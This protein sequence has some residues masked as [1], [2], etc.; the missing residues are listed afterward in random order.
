M[1]RRLE[2]PA[3]LWSE[4]LGLPE[5]TLEDLKAIRYVCRTWNNIISCILFNTLYLP[6]KQR[7]RP[8]DQER[9]KRSIDLLRHIASSPNF[10]RHFEVISIDTDL[11]FQVSCGQM[12][13]ESTSSWKSRVTAII[14]RKRRLD[15]WACIQD[16]IPHL[17]ALRRMDIPWSHGLCPQMEPII[18]SLPPLATLAVNSERQ[19]FP[20][21][22]LSQLRGLTTLQAGSLTKTTNYITPIITNNPQLKKID[23]KWWE[24][25]VDLRALFAGCPLG[26][27]AC[28][29]SF[30]GHTLTVPHFRH[31]TSLQVDAE[32]PEALWDI[33]RR[34]T[35]HLVRVHICSVSIAFVRYVASYRGIERLELKLWAV[36]CPANV[37]SLWEVISLHKTT[38]CLL[39]LGSRIC[40]LCTPTIQHLQCLRSLKRLTLAIPSVSDPP[41]PSKIDAELEEEERIVNEFLDHLEDWPELEV[42]MFEHEVHQYE[43]DHVWRILEGQSFGDCRRLEIRIDSYLYDGWPRIRHSLKSAYVMMRL[44]DGSF[45]FRIMSQSGSLVESQR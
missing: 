8:L 10:A 25:E 18:A 45:A 13:W 5:H 14:T 42:V 21:E 23:L 26:T 7:N 6:W 29:E 12:P 30:M 38:L 16:V 39:A 11:C 22:A 40:T 33:L 1:N 17:T 44:H 19:L 4:I 15:L 20:F 37:D 34:E 35:V 2:L 9:L 24:G 3:E 36:K 27:P 31:L 43:S 32:A 41:D 28:V